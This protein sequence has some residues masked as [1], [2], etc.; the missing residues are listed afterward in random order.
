M[1]RAQTTAYRLRWLILVVGLL[2]FV[3]GVVWIVGMHWGPGAGLVGTPWFF[4]FAFADS[5][6]LKLWDYLF[7]SM[8]FLGLFLLTQWMFLRPRRGW[9]FKLTSKGRPMPVSIVAA[10]FITMLLTV[11][12]AAT[13]LEL[14]FWW[15]ADLVEPTGPY[16]G[17][18]WLAMVLIWGV[19]SVIFFLYWRQGDRYTQMG[20]VIRGLV[21]GSFLELFVAT[22]VY[23]WDPHKQQ[24][25]CYCARGSY[26]GRVF[27]G[28]V[29]MWA[30]GPGIV[31]LFLREKYRMQ[32]LTPLCTSCGYD[33]RGTIAAGRTQCPECGTENPLPSHA[34]SDQTR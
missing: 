34:V 6:V 13:L 5:P 20:K 7:D 33:L 4:I 27:G 25:E 24:D 32:K 12:F 11:G 1:T 18:L 30:F 21:A 22:A 19:W 23:V 9:T 8:L 15:G 28:T 2:C 26:T 3:A 16:L 14:P 31:L 10:A 29:L 17:W